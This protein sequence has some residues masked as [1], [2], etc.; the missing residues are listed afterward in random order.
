[1]CIHKF[2][3]F[4]KKKMH[5]YTFI[6]LL[7]AIH[8]CVIVI[9]IFPLLLFFFDHIHDSAGVSI[10]NISKT[11]H[12]YCHL[13]YRWLLLSEIFRTFFFQHVIKTINVIQKIHFENFHKCN[14]IATIQIKSYTIFGNKH[15]LM[16][17]LRVNLWQCEW[18]WKSKVAYTLV[19]IFCA[20]VEIICVFSVDSIF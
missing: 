12:S 3:L 13:C 10:S 18:K 16:N 5:F 2:R 11:Y 1:M 17:T 4:C 9:F 19:Y 20:P 15:T 6:L 7:L 8:S 14:W